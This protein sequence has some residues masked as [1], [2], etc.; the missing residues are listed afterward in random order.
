MCFAL[1][2]GEG[3]EMLPADGPRW[4]E[5]NIIMLIRVLGAEA[6]IQLVSNMH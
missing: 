3:E 2:A 5:I 6:D 1:E 4:M